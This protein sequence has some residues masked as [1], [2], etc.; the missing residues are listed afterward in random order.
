M[1]RGSPQAPQHLMR[2]ET[3]PAY[4]S[5]KGVG[6]FVKAVLPGGAGTTHM[7]SSVW[8]SLVWVLCC[9]MCTP[10]V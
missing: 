9:K 8:Q 6:L 1:C 5:K 3:G 2:F 10:A 4:E 7:A